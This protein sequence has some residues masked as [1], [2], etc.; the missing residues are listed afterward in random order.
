VKDIEGLADPT[1]GDVWVGC[2]EPIA[3]G[4]LPAIIER[5]GRRYPRI[6]CHVVQTPTTATLEYR[7]LRD[8]Q[9]DMLIGRIREPFTDDDLQPDILFHQRLHVVAG[10]RSKW[11]RRRKIEL[12]ELVDEP[13]LLP[14]PNTLPRSLVE[15]VFHGHGLRSPRAGVVS[16]SFN[17]Y[18]SLLRTGR[19]LTALPGSVLYYG[20]LRSTVKLLPVEFPNQPKPVAIIALK[21]R[22][23]SPVAQ[24]FIDCAHEIAKPLAK[25]R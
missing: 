22:T 25:P 11:A 20:A 3:I 6:V 15:E 10:K 13:W 1:A 19:Y 5:L 16:L 7:E 8:R 4:I 12:A 14:L 18:N 21:H 23:L 24:L 17:L 9:V 2:S